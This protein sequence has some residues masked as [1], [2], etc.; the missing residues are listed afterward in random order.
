[1]K[2]WF[3]IQNPNLSLLLSCWDMPVQPYLPILS[4]IFACQQSQEI[5]LTEPNWHITLIPSMDFAFCLSWG[6]T[7][8]NWEDQLWDAKKRRNCSWLRCG[9]DAATIE[10]VKALEVCRNIRMECYF[11]WRI[12]HNF[13]R[14][15]SF[16]FKICMR[17]AILNCHIHFCFCT[18]HTVSLL[19][20]L[21]HLVSLPDI[22][23][24]NIILQS[25]I[26]SKY[27]SILAEAEGGHRKEGIQFTWIILHKSLKE[28]S[29]NIKKREYVG[30]VS[31]FLNSSL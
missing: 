21:R 31:I 18:E 5:P 25:A 6:I 27:S 29:R 19:F 9:W 10:N 24:D 8:S 22:I 30:I 11:F 12:W 14:K 1:M 15:Y 7:V 26:L 20:F 28:N 16:C 3:C 17:N 23:T 4:L 13:E 2:F